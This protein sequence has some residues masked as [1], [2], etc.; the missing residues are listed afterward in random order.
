MKLSLITALVV[1][2]FSTSAQQRPLEPSDVYRFKDISSPQISPE[3]K[4]VAY[5]LTSVDS[6]KDKRSSD[7][8][9]V[10]WDGKESVQLTHS[11]ENESRPKWSP[12]GRFLSFISSRKAGIEKEEEGSQVWVMDRRGGEA[13]K[14]T[15]IKADLEDYSWS[16]DGKKLLLTLRDKDQSDTAKSKV[17]TPIVINRYKFK[18]DY[19]GYLD[20]RNSH[21][22][23]FNIDTRK[24]DTLTRGIYTENEAAWS[25]DGS[26]IVFVSNRTADPDK[27]NNTELFVMEARSGALPRQLTSWEGSD[28]QPVWSPDGKWIAYLQS[29]S[30]QAFTMYGQSI[31]AI[32]PKD[33]GTPKLLSQSSD[34]PVRSPRWTKDGRSIWVLMDD[35]RQVNIVSFTTDG[36]RKNISVGERAYSIL[37]SNPSTNS[38]MA[39]MSEP[40]LPTE[41]YAIENNS[42]RRMT[43]IHDDF[44]A[45]LQLATVQGFQSKSRDGALISNLLFL[46]PGA[47]AGEKLPLVLF[48]H[49]GPV[50]QDSYRFDMERQMYAA[51]GFAVAAVNYR[52]SNGRGLEFIRSIY[53]DWGNKEVMDVIGATD[54]LV[55][56]GIADPARLGLGGWSYGG[57]TTNYTIATDTRYKAAVSGAGSSLQLTLYGTDQYVTQYETEIGA[58]WANPQKWIDISYPFFKADRIQTPTLFLSGQNDFNVPV[59][60]SEQ[61]YQALRSLGVPTELVIY[62]GQFHGLS[63]PS[64]VKDRHER[65]ISWFNRHLNGKR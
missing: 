62:P 57:I 64:Y 18:Q 3:G 29:S 37:E 59:A 55:E 1:L 28:S 25:P 22:Y 5:V 58:P 9:M 26:E 10:S 45:P 34:R 56:K 13:K 11:P 51:A 31:L 32:I 30:N 54:H 46:P 6:V 14:L 20:S 48:I 15:N 65:H 52:G 4:W 12:D 27:N 35:D 33:G 23:I 60:G 47:K 53:G 2:A 50:G 17:K 21:L 42:P 8:W 7:L 24:L 49:G 36:V 61:M 19:Q 43:H 38:W 39:M 16:P 40:Q 63:V 44:L 41:I